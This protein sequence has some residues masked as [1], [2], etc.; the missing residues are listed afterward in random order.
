MAIMLVLIVDLRQLLGHGGG[1]DHLMAYAE[2]TRTEAADRAAPAK[3]PSRFWRKVRYQLLNV[4]AGLVLLYLFIPISVIILFSFNDPAGKFNLTWNKFS[5]R[6]LG[7]P[8]RRAGLQDA[9]VLSIKIAFLSTLVA[10]VLGT[11]VA[12]A[13]ARYSFRGRS[14]TNFAIFTPMATPEI[15]MGSSLLTLFI[16]L[17]SRRPR[18]RDD[19]DR[20][21]HVQHQLR[22][23]DGEGAGVRLRP[24]AGGG[25][26]G[27][28]RQRV[29]HLPQDHAAAD[30]ARHRRRRG[31]RLRAL[32]RRLRRHPV[33]QRAPRSRSRCTSTAPPET[34]CPC[35]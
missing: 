20:P 10:T 29:D 2:A 1:D 31:A 30:H 34:A 11:L 26:H 16:A 12:L 23:R 21:H 4:F 5:T 35:R 14:A 7:A 18:L 13:L 17:R 24:P 33:Q 32:D 9:V 3:P 25:G 19:P 22:D 28:V 6:R 15:V 27:S 8:V